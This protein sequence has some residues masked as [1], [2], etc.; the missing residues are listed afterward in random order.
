MMSAMVETL[1]EILLAI[2]L[3]FGTYCR[4][5]R[6]ISLYLHFVASFLVILG[7]FG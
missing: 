6:L 2:L 7:D 5:Y 4:L 1:G 3:L